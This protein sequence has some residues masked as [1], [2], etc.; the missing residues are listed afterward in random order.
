MLKMTEADY[1]ARR[2]ECIAAAAKAIL[3]LAKQQQMGAADS[4]QNLI[5]KLASDV[6]DAR[7][8]IPNLD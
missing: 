7:D 1:I 8:I 6:N 2:D 4:W 5:E 3:P